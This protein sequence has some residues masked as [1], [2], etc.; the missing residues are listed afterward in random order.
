[1]LNLTYQLEI[2]HLFIQI[3]NVMAILQIMG[4]Q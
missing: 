3:D 1:M 2:Q 4:I